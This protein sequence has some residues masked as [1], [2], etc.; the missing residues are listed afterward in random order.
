M[1][2]YAD[3][4][5]WLATAPARW[6]P[7]VRD[8]VAATTALRTLVANPKPTLPAWTVRRPKPIGTLRTFYDEAATRWGVPWHYLAAVHFIETKMGRIEGNSTAGAQGP[9][10]FLPST[11][12]AYG[13][14]DIHDDHDAI[15]GAARYLAAN[16]APTRMHDALFH[17]NR[18]EQ[19]VT[20]IT[21]YAERM[22]VDP[23]AYRGYWGWQVYFATTRGAV[24]LREGW[25]SPQ[26]RPVTD[27]DL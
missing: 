12:A 25:S 1:R 13:T 11:W 3:H 6:Q 23:L 21:A 9:M 18:S 19:Y 15:L 24:W 2:A 4:A 27:A 17:Y 26:E 10:Q 16:G 22:R 5:D 20:A 14:G 8:D 7:A